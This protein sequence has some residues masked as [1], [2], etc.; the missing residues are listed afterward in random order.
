MTPMRAIPLMLLLG[1]AAIAAV[2][3]APKAAASVEAR[4]RPRDRRDQ[5]ERDALLAAHGDWLQ[6]DGRAVWQPRE[7]GFRPF[8]R[9]TWS[10]DDGAWTFR[11]PTAWEEL[12][13]HSGTWRRDWLSGWVWTP[14]GSWR[15]APVAWRLGGG[16]IGWAPLDEEG[17]APSDPM[18]WVFVK[19]VD[20]VGEEIAEVRAAPARSTEL[21]AL[22]RPVDAPPTPL[23]LLGLDEQPAVSD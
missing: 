12:T 7:I 22:T 6:L 13:A 2:G 17:R 5:R 18:A 19:G 23:A 10:V 8:A 9:G 4:E 14:G 15:P 20:A 16:W 11:A 3:A 21:F 1:G